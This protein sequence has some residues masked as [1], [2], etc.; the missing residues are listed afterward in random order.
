MFFP[1]ATVVSAMVLSFTGASFEL[2]PALASKAAPASAKVEPATRLAAGL[3]APKKVTKQRPA[4]KSDSDYEQSEE[5]LLR[6][7]SAPAPKTEKSPAGR[8][9]KPIIMDDNQD[10]EEGDEA[11]EDEDEDGP[12]VVKKR[13]RVVEEEDDDV[14][15]AIP[16]LQPILPRIFN[17]ELG[18][19]AQKRSFAYDLPTM[20]GDNSFRFGY[21]IG[22]EAYPMLALPNGWFRTLGIGGSYAKEY[23]DAITEGMSGMF[24]GYPV[25]QGR[26]GFDVRYAIPVGERVVLMP[27]LGYG[28]MSADLKRMSPLS[29]SSCLM[30]ETAP[31]FAD[32]KTSYVSAD[33]HIRVAATETLGLSLSGGYLAGLGVASGMDQIA[34]QAPADMKGFH[35]EASARLLIKDWFA[36]YAAVPLRRYSFA[37]GAPPSGTTIM[38]RSAGDTYVGVTVGVAIFTY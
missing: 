19:S 26:W 9:R 21:Q 5:E 35:V 24:T 10:E 11:E 31:C 17:F 12:R 32:I 25:S 1:S 29:P 20:Q 30:A 13:K 6:S 15:D 27:A 23:G 2:S 4:R 34:A 37:F 38:Y 33:F 14:E 22:L 7:P 8:R 3:W 16:S 36:V 18:T 28:N